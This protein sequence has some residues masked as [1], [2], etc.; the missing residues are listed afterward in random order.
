MKILFYNVGYCTGLRGAISEYLIGVWRYVIP[1]NTVIKKLISFIK[2]INPDILAL[3]EID[4]ISLRTGGVNYI[5]LIKQEV[6]F[7]EATYRSKY[8]MPFLVQLPVMGA[9]CNAVFTKQKIQ[10]SHFVDLSSGVKRLV[11]EVHLSDDLDLFLVHLALGQTTR[12]AQLE[13]LS[14]ILGKSNKKHIL[15]GD[16][17]TFRGSKE[18]EA[19]M[20]DN[21][22]YS[23]NT[24]HKPT[25]PTVNPKKEFDFILISSSIKIK[26]F[27][28]I[29]SELSDHLPLF[30]EIE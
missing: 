23:V 30:L 18:L 10:S 9:Q 13:E 27:Q 8:A 28:V 25:F 22:L 26:N 11:I 4:S 5:E 12:T 1:G 24:L 6:V 19:L 15:L 14:E 17:N 2:N 29:Q 21:H 3:V 16:F 20:N 7:N